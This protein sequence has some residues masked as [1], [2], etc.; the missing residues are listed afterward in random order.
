M[1]IRL[2]YPFPRGPDLVGPQPESKRA[3]SLKK[4]GIGLLIVTYYTKKRF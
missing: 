3:L 1:L 2:A 4:Y